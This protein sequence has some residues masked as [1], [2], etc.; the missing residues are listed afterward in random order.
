MRNDFRS[1]KAV[2]LILAI[3]LVTIALC[4]FFFHNLYVFMLLSACLL[5][6]LSILLN[7]AFIQNSKS[8]VLLLNALE[9][10]DYSLRFSEN[11]KDNYNK[12][13]NITLNRIKEILTLARTSVMEQEK[14]FAAAVETVSTGIIICEHSG[15]V[16]N[17]NRAAHRL[18]GL[19][20]ISHIKQLAFVDKGLDERIMALQENESMIVKIETERDV[21]QLNVKMTTGEIQ[22]SIYKIFT[23]NNI[24]SELEAHETESWIRLI[25]V[26]THEIMNSIAPISSISETLTLR[27]EKEKD[28]DEPIDKEMLQ[29]GLDTIRSTSHSL[30]NFVQDYRRFT[31]VP[32]PEKKTFAL[33]PLI[34][35]ILS[36][37]RQLKERNGIEISMNIADDF[38]IHADR[39][40]MQQVLLN[41][42]KNAYEAPFPPEVQPTVTLSGSQG[43]Q[44]EKFIYISNNGRPIPSDVVPNIFIP[45]YT[46]KENGSGIGLSLSRYIMRRH[47]G[48]LV[49]L[50]QGG[51]T[52]FRID[53]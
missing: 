30:L 18:L 23:I 7:N 38:T 47:N 11:K 45:F 8:L 52:I 24:E 10:S 15:S 50:Q 16:R 43:P 39:K 48:N 26:M 44:N 19:P 12:N 29:M 49:Y 3:I 2:F 35:E 40:L 27:L 28:D 25:R 4:L 34:N 20:S 22:S 14:F 31:S 41:L 9:N 1:S 13:V 42:I 51:S 32:I 6:F 53:L 46:T 33:K 5:V 36:L 21:R 37:L 17:A